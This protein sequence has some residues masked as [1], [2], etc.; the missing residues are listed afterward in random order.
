[1]P[2]RL[3]GRD[4]DIWRRYTLYSWTQEKIAAHYGISRERVSDILQRVRASLP[5]TDRAELI[6]AS[7]ELIHEVKAR[8]LEIADMAGA[9]VAV[10]KD[11]IV[12][13]DPNT[14]EPVRDYSGRL[15]A[16]DM[17]LKADDVLA[18]R[19]GLDAAQKTEST[20]TVRYEVV[21]IEPEALQ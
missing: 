1:M 19:L 15:R 16:L 4:G 2:E 21:G 13:L 20:A 17:A 6:N 8:A 12:L 18:K 11:G 14:G 7:M 10:G 3:E 5:E 9:P